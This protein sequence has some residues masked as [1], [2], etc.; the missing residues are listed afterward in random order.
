MKT[1][2]EID[3]VF[4][5]LIIN[6]IQS[7]DFRLEYFN[8]PVLDLRAVFRL[9]QKGLEELRKALKYYTAKKSGIDWDFIK[10]KTGYYILE[11]C[12]R[13]EDGFLYFNTRK[14]EGSIIISKK[15][16]EHLKGLI[17]KTP[18]KE[19]EDGLVENYF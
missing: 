17:S 2:F 15:N 5:S 14:G 19:D 11:I 13:P 10:T 12:F 1:T 6:F 3:S 16:A 18:A 9:S 7:K 8:N 4:E